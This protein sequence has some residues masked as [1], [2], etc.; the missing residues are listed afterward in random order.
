MKVKRRHS[1]KLSLNH[2]VQIARLSAGLLLLAVTALVSGCALSGTNNGKTDLPSSLAIESSSMPGAHV[3]SVY[4]ASLV[5]TGGKPPYSWSIPAGTL[6]SGLA[7]TPS[8]GT[9]AGVPTETGT[10]SFSAQVEDSSSPVNTTT[11]K[12]SIQVSLSTSFSIQTSSVPNGLVGSP[13]SA[14]L[15]QTGGVSPIHWLI[16]SGKLPTGLTLDTATGA[17]SGTPQ[18]SGSFNFIAQAS[19]STTPTPQTASQQFSLGISGAVAITTA[20]LPNGNVN[21]AYSAA[22]SATGG[23]PPYKWSLASGSLPPG[24]VLGA[25]NGTFSGIATNAASYSFQLQVE[26]SQAVTAVASLKITVDTAQGSCGGP[27]VYCARTDMN[28]QKE[29]PMPAPA[30]NAVFNDPDFGSQMVR[31]T[32]SQILTGAGHPNLNYITNSSAE[33]NTWNTDSTKFYVIG[34]GGNYLLYSFDAATMQ[35]TWDQIPNSNNSAIPVEGDAFSRT[36]P[37]VVYGWVNGPG[38]TIAE[39]NISSNTTTNLVDTSSCVPGLSLVSSMDDVS[40]SAGDQ[41]LLTYEGG[42]VQDTDMFVVVYDR[43][44]GCRWYNTQTG[45][46]GGQWGPSGPATTRASFLLHNARIAISGDWA[47]LDG[48]TQRYVWEIGTQNVY[49]CSINSS[50][51]CGGH[52]VGG[53]THLINSSGT[54]DDMNVVIRPFS[55]PNS[56]IPLIH[57]LP[58]PVEWTYDKHWSWNDDDLSD[59]MPVCGSTYLEQVGGRSI[60]RTWDREVVCIRTD[61]VQSE[62]WRFAHNRSVYNGDFE[63]TPRGNVSQDGKFFMFTSTWENQLG[64]QTGSRTLYREDV[65]IVR[66]Y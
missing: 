36:D 39:Y 33:Q 53:Y 60:T 12:V 17:I 16:S 57:P 22:A 49:L 14:S 13:Y 30:V 37:N 26:D 20:S 27:P 18:Q 15:S 44:S 43:T 6:P 19:D 52:T 47:V 62:V 55:L 4:L 29:T 9:V 21:R 32:D 61:G 10:V 25:S 40:V 66:L 65:F 45:Q 48:T 63:S 3:Q 59:S 64:L 54:V 41:R 23:A 38:H 46:I 28:L 31:V 11:R 1:N 50:P 42:P 56:S 58:T 2:A 8:T 5:A 24:I 34:T 35:V 51:Y 7:L